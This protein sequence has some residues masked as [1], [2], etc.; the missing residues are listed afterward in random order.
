MLIAQYKFDKSAYAINID[1]PMY[2]ISEPTTFNGSGF[3]DTGIQLFKND[4]NWTMFLDCIPN[5]NDIT[6]AVI[7]CVDE[8]GTWPG[9]SFSFEPNGLINIWDGTKGTVIGQDY[10]NKNIKIVIVKKD[11]NITIYHNNDS[12]YQIASPIVIPYT[13]KS[14]NT[15]LS[16]GG[17]HIGT[18]AKHPF[19]GV[20]NDFILYNR[21]LEEQE[22][23]SIIMNGLLPVFNDDFNYK[24]IDEYLDTDR[25]IVT[26]SIYSDTDFTSCSFENQTS[27][28]TVEYLKVT[29][30]VTSTAEM[31]YNC[32]SLTSVNASDWDTSNVTGMWEMFYWCCDLKEI[33][34]IENW[35]TSSL[36]DLTYTF[37]CCE[38]LTSLNLSGWDTSNVTCTDEMFS[39]CTYLEELDMSNWDLSNADP[40]YIPY[41]FYI[42]ELDPNNTEY[43]K[44]DFKPYLKTIKCD[45]TNTIS[46]IAPYLPVSSH[47]LL[48]GK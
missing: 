9:I 1:S 33:I 31:F 44:P 39:D 35:N 27:L 8:F 20:I 34:G 36:D 17:G 4:S 7:H 10:L 5:R 41:M 28:L 30:E 32:D 25:N 48:S 38:S 15:T 45:N 43:Y 26:R 47:V 13:F 14:A 22:C 3:I 37:F 40:E 21:A 2:Q 12:I 23:E 16:I 42:S 18:S 29:N 24:I 46:L 6:Q 11:D 19:S